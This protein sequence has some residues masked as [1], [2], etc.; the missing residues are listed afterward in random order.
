MAMSLEI[1]G[2]SRNELM[3]MDIAGLRAILHER[4]HHTIEVMLYRILQDKINKPD[5]FGRQA[6]FVLDV[7][8]ERGLPLDTPD[9]EWVQRNI[10]LADKLNKGEEVELNTDIPEP[11]SDEE[12]NVVD[13]L[14]YDR[15]SIRQFKDKTISEELVR[16]L[17]HAG[18]YSP[19]G[20]NLDSRRFIV[21]R[22]PEEWKMVRSDIPLENCVMILVCQDMNV[23][24]ALSHYQAASPQNV[25]FD[26]ATAADHICLMAHALGLGA[27]WLT[28]GEETQKRIRDYFDL[29]E[30]F[31][32]RC[33]I[34]VGWPDEAPI[35][36]QRMSL[37]DAIL[38]KK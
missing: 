33:H 28:H 20:C 3:E 14:L 16:K 26:A 29:P 5:T 7:W 12:L 19:Q 15:R 6:K 10:D 4:T 21:L 38:T 13:K 37:E 8:K 32:T 2:Y 17:L 11:F 18:L 27:C 24:N 36:S 25:Y 9:L 35:K 31:I 34:V 1:H 22:D 23:Y 30:T